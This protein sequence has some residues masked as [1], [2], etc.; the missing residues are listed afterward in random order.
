MNQPTHLRFGP[1]LTRQTL[2]Q[3]AKP[4]APRIHRFTDAPD[5]FAE[6]IREAVLTLR[7][8]QQG[9]LNV[10]LTISLG[11]ASV[12]PEA[13]QS[14]AELIKSADVALYKAKKQGRNC[15]VSALSAVSV[16]N[17]KLAA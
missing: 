3:T 2:W 16:D 13:G 14:P 10:S 1:T 12:I 9:R 17:K 6:E 8:R 11:V 7:I 15:C 4:V 5:G